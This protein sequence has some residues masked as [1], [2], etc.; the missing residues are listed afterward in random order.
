ME[1]TSPYV[2]NNCIPYLS[3]PSPSLSLSLSLYLSISL[4]ISLSPSLSPLSLSPLSLLSLP[5]LSLS[6][7]LSLRSIRVKRLEQKGELET[8]K[9]TEDQ[10]RLRMI[11]DSQLMR[12]E[13]EAFYQKYQAIRRFAHQKNI[14]LPVELDHDTPRICPEAGR[15]T[16]L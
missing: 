12:E 6:L 3:L 2:T 5:P 7:C 14:R 16:A 8:E 11:E 4:Y 9:T 1:Y 10:E 15:L 13:I